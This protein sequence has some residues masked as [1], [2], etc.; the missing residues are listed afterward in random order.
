MASVEYRHI[1]L[2]EIPGTRHAELSDKKFDAFRSNP[3]A[4]KEDYWQTQCMVNGNPAGRLYYVPLEILAG[5]DKYRAL[6]GSTLFVDSRY[7]KYRI[8]LKLP[9]FKESLAADRIGLGGGLSNMSLPVHQFLGYHIFKLQRSFLLKNSFPVVSTKVHGVLGAFSAKCIN[10]G[11]KAFWQ[12]LRMI[13]RIQ[14]RNYEIRPL[15]HASPEIEKLAID[16]GHLFRENHNSAWFEWH[17]NHSFCE[18]SYATQQLFELRIKRTNEFV[19]FFM[20]KHRFYR[21]ASHRGYK[22]VRLGS[23]IEW[24]CA[25]E[26]IATKVRIVL[27][28]ISTMKPDIDAVEFC[29]DD[30]ELNK[31]LRK[32]GFIP[33]GACRFAVKAT[34]ETPFAYHT[35]YEKQQNWR[36]RSACGD[37][38]L[39]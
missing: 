15:D 2:E 26:L 23:V 38:G 25:E 31:Q 17:L 29:S 16:D 21:Q 27:S 37:N 33:V 4:R 22:N 3:F 9:M 11:L 14:L 35:G 13:S 34:P 24:G 1:T 8:G 20:T 30:I 18:D 36:L 5:N 7:R 39:S 19:G 32:Y 10:L 28:A 12:V 6:S